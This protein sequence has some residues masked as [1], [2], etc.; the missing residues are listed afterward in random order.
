[1]MLLKNVQKASAHIQD[2]GLMVPAKSEMHNFAS[3]SRCL[4]VLKPSK[5][6]RAIETGLSNIMLTYLR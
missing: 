5:V 2:S 6:E 1:M 4:A 3:L